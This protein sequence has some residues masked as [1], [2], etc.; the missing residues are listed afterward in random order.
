M[1]GVGMKLL[2]KGDTVALVNIGKMPPKRFH[3][4]IILVEKYL[5]EMGYQVLNLLDF[6]DIISPIIKS[7]QINSCFFDERIRA[8][9]PISTGDLEIEVLENV[10]Y[11]AI[12]NHPKIICGYSGLSTLILMITLKTQMPTFY[13]PHLNFLS[14]YSSQRE[15]LFSVYS[16]W[17]LFQGQGLGKGRLKGFEKK[18]I[19]TYP[20]EKEQLSFKNI[21]SATSDLKHTYINSYCYHQIVTGVVY[22]TTLEAFSKLLRTHQISIEENFI[23][24]LDVFDQTFEQIIDDIKIICNSLDMKICKCI[25]FSTICYRESATDVNMFKN[26]VDHLL[27]YLSN[28]VLPATVDLLY[29]FP[30]GHSR[31]KLTLPNGVQGCICADTGDIYFENFWEK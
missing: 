29:G 11:D 7:T 4:Q 24:V 28:S 23:L 19:F 1:G 14:E 17:N 8:I 31:Y 15:N 10:D 9:F 25:Y 16:F 13:G 21:Y 20:K 26:S 3:N 22:I 12:Q 6:D 18:T 2:K 30:I 5:V 27:N